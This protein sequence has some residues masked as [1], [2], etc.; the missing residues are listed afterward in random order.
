MKE[1]VNKMPYYTVFK[2]L[3]Y[4]FCCLCIQAARFALYLKIFFVCIC[5]LHFSSHFC[6]NFYPNI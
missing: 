3:F 1:P 4:V 5:N 6:V 2:I